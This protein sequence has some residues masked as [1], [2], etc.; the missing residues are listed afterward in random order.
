[1][2]SPFLVVFLATMKKTGFK[3]HVHNIVPYEKMVTGNDR[4]KQNVGG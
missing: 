4:Q 1:M 3:W 2:M